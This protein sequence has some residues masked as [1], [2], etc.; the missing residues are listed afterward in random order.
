MQS[1]LPDSEY[2]ENLLNPKA[3]IWSLD[4]QRWSETVAEFS[5]VLA[6]GY[7]LLR[8]FWI[9]WWGNNLLGDT[10]APTW[11]HTRIHTRTHTHKCMCMHTHARTCRCVHT[12]FHPHLFQ[13][14]S[15]SFFLLLSR[16]RTLP[17]TRAHS[18]EDRSHQHEQVRHIRKH[19]NSY[20]VGTK[21]TGRRRENF[22]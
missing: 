15:I 8:G 22:M 4:L 18:S 17:H 21:R 13:L 12:H 6:R 14:F 5:R 10:C 19:W 9:S 3:S 2:T 11:T 7:C 20:R 16:F 1:Q